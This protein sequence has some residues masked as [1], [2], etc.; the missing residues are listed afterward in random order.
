MQYLLKALI[1]S[2]YVTTQVFA[3][4]I[5]HPKQLGMGVLHSCV[6]DELGVQ[7]WGYNE[8]GQA[9]VPPL[10]NPKF[11]LSGSLETTCALDDDGLQCWGSQAIRNLNIGIKHPS[12]VSGWGIPLF[13]IEKGILKTFPVISD[14]SQFLMNLQNPQVVV[15]AGGGSSACVLDDTGV[16]C[17]GEKIENVPALVNTFQISAGWQHACALHDGG[18]T[19]WGDNTYG[20]T[21][22]PK[23]EGPKLVASAIHS[24][25][26]V[27]P[28]GVTCWG[29]PK[30]PD[31]QEIKNP[32]ALALGLYHGCSIENDTVKCW[33][34]NN[35]GQL[36]IPQ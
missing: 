15:V 2:L 20:Q 1:L 30:L 6:L 11:L 12:K 23:L 18:V 24:S 34:S 25:C 35:Y 22:V 4:P 8:K 13:A 10:K 36:N 9:T 7:C 31:S 5:I 14:L 33:G 28:K 17:F 27:D 19:C 29:N 3:R 32:T 16:H 26:A 21:N